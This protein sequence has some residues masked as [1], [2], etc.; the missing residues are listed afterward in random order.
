MAVK[1]AQTVK[2]IAYIIYID[3]IQE[4]NNI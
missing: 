4:D 3:G 1:M 2:E